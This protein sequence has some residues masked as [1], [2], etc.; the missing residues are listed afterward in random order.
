MRPSCHRRRRRRRE[1]QSA[2][3]LRRRL[4]LTTLARI[5]TGDLPSGVTHRR[6]AAR[7]LSLTGS[8][9]HGLTT[10]ILDILDGALPGAGRPCATLL[11]IV[12]RSILDLPSI[13][14]DYE[15]EGNR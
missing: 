5:V 1:R 3:E 8:L 9:T 4:W 11:Y 13:S 14:E 15:G 12:L 10:P 2:L 7:A 6:Y